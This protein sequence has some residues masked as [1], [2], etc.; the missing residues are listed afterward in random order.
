MDNSD[1]RSIAHSR[2]SSSQAQR[3]RN[4][5]VASHSMYRNRRSSI[6]SNATSFMDDVEMAQDE[7]ASVPA[8]NCSSCI[9]PNSDILW[10][11]V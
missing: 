11:N 5:S 9:D 3:R 2:R 10:A 7:V 1:N 6:M 4:G 8:V